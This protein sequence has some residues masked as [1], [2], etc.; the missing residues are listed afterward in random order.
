[1]NAA[2]TVISSRQY[3]AQ[4]RDATSEFLEQELFT[5]NAFASTTNF[6]NP[7]PYEGF[8]LGSTQ[9]TGIF[10]EFLKLL[11]MITSLERQAV[12]N[13]ALLQNSGIDPSGLR[14][15]FEQARSR[16]MSIG[17]E[18]KSTNEQE[19][20]HLTRTANCFYHAGLIYS[21]RALLKADPTSAERDMQFTTSK[22][23]LFRCLEF[24]VSSKATMQDLVWPLFIAGTE[25]THPD[26][27]AMVVTKLKEAMAGTGFSNC[28]RALDFLVALW[29]KRDL[30]ALKESEFDWIAFAREWTGEGR[31]FLVF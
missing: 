16:T 7:T 30:E 22:F 23:E 12:A 1:M 3:L 10:V 18:F 8:A 28:Q 4:P 26:E 21:H 15:L 24:H 19:Y 13:T 27:R 5:A 29:N 2:R 6:A 20:L 11:Q 14:K 31:T 25:A 17:G 9:P